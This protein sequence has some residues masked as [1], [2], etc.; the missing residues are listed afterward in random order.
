[1]NKKALN[2][3]T[4][5]KAEAMLELQP[6]FDSSDLIV[7]HVNIRSLRKHCCDLM[8]DPT[9]GQMAV[10]CMNLGAPDIDILGV[11]VRFHLTKHHC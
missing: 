8:N 3:I 6:P 10:L 11:T 5:L 1:M 7:G 4:R 9:V 2:D